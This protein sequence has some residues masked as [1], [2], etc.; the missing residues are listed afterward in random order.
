MWVLT[1]GKMFDGHLVPAGPRL[2]TQSTTTGAGNEIRPHAGPH[3]DRPAPARA[4]LGRLT[5]G[6][7]GARAGPAGRAPPRRYARLVVM[8]VVW[9]GPGPGPPALRHPI[10]VVAFEGWFDVARAATGAVSWLA[11]EFDADAVAGIDPEPYF[12]FTTRR[13][14]VRC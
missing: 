2:V 11:G 10:L 14:M 6:P 7:D 8:T 1:G 9:A 4:G 5:V 3:L 13:P 12:D